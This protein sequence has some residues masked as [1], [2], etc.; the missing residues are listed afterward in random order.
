[1]KNPYKQPNIY[2]DKL[3]FLSKFIKQQFPK[4][5]L[6]LFVDT[7]VY[8]Q[9]H[10]TKFVNTEIIL[11]DCK[12]YK[13]YPIDKFHKGIFPMFVRFIPMF[14][15]TNNIEIVSDSDISSKIT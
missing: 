7:N 3:L 2:T 8:N 1:M 4:A 15:P 11:F 12:K 9:I 13:E 10:K 14:M 5:T 6:R